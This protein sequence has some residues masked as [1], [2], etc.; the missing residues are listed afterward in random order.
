[1]DKYLNYNNLKSNEEAIKNFLLD[2]NCLDALKPWI[3]KINIFD[4]LKISRTEIRHSNILA[5]LLDANENH[6]IGDIFIRSV[7]QRLIQNNLDYFNSNKINV[8][9]L[10]TLDFS[11]F[12]IMREWNNID[13]LL[14]SQKDR[15]VICIENKINIGE[16]SN[17]L[18]RYREK[19]QETFP[20]EEGYD[21]IFIYLTPDKALPSDIDAWMPLSYVEILDILN[22]SIDDKGLEPRV[23]LIIENYIETLRR[24][25]VK[26]KE[27]VQ[28]CINIY[29][30]HK[31]A[32]DLIFE[33]RPDSGNI[34]AD[35]VKEYLTNRANISRDI[36]Y[37]PNYSTKTLQRFSTDYFNNIFPPVPNVQGY[38][39]EGINY[40]WE[41]RNNYSTGKLHVKFV[42][43]NYDEWN[44]KKAERLSKLLNKEL[45][46]NWQWKTFY[47]FNITLASPD[48]VEEYFEGEYE[49]IKKDIF[50]KLD[51][52]ME[53]VLK[54]EK[55]VNELWDE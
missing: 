23:K 43:C 29:K 18:V 26:D 55:K 11:N 17:Q 25:V 35:I 27:L 31:Q 7:I 46:D 51:A 33:N 40:F 6:G 14:L 53:R 16:H 38:W 52:A 28:I 49:D 20:K 3:S 12:T 48:R 45:K 50:T 37:E 19:V 13:I 21:A 15:F 39:G 54:F 44:G 10:L 5:W 32:L 1:M 8:L 41:I 4:I 2:I 24:Y 47:S 30:K 9:E 36:I 34:V 42:M 22:N